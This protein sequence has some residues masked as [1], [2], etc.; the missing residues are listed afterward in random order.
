MSK[1]RLSGSSPLKPS[2][3]VTARNWLTACLLV[4]LGIGC[5]SKP[6]QPAPPRHPA[7]EPTP[8]AEPLSAVGNH[9]PYRVMGATY[10]VLA[11]AN[12]YN[13]Q[14]IASWYGPNFHGKPTSNQEIFD[15]YAFTAA[16]RTL[17]LPSYVRVTR[18]DTRDSVVVRVN[19][20]GPFK[21]G[22]IIDL[23]FAAAERLNMIN[24]G[25][26]RVEVSV[27][28][29]EG[30]DNRP[31]VAT[32]NNVFLQVGAFSRRENALAMLNQLRQ[33]EISAA[34]LQTTRDPRGNAVHR[35]RVGPLSDPSSA[36]ILAK[37]LTGW[38]FTNPSVVF[39]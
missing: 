26:A 18:L 6:S 33:R 13:E 10:R 30:G 37:K 15:M 23:S 34:Q 35:V 31:S 21:K 2:L 38:G 16:H 5:A 24:A 12:G 20:R 8:R 22:R 29:P 17:P 11:S 1:Q 36:E 32:A 28:L 19:D 39:E 25:T 27:I 14:G 9:S 7:V 3:C 4:F